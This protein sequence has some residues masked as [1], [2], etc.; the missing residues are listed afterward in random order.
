MIHVP[1][2]PDP[3]CAE[4]FDA[5]I[6][7]GA[8]SGAATAIQLLARNPGLRVG[9]IE[10]SAQFGR[11]VGESTVEVSSYFLGRVLGLTQHLNEKHLHKQGLRFF[12]SAG[13]EANLAECSELGPKYLPRLPGYQVDRAVLDEE[14]W[15]RA[16]AAGAV[17]FRPAQALGYERLASGGAVVRL[18]TEAGEQS[19]QA[20][21]L[22]DASGVRTLV[23][24]QEGWWES[25]DEHPTAS[26]WSRW[27]GVQDLDGAALRKA[28]P[29]WSA[30][31][32]GTRFTATNHLVGYGWWSW[33]IPL[34]DGDMSV[35]IVFDQRLV[36]LPEGPS[37]GAR[38]R[39]FLEQHPGAR[40]LLAHAEFTEGDVHL[41]RNLAY[42]TTRMAEDGVLLVGDA[43]G[44]MDPFYS[45]GLDWITYTSA[46]AAKVVVDE[47]A[48]VA[49]GA[50]LA[51]H[52]DVTFRQS[53]T[54][55]FEA[56]YR[57]K[58]FYLGDYELMSLA[59]RLDLGL[60]YLGVASQPYLR[61]PESLVRPSFGDR[62]STLPFYLIR[63]YHRRLV[64]IAQARRER[65]VWG[66]HN[67]GR[68]LPFNSYRFHPTLPIRVGWALLNWGWLEICEGWRSW[69]RKAAPVVKPTPAP[70]A[71]SS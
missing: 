5:L 1:P 48:G 17:P 28:H 14:V 18:R 22:I 45:P 42:R 70:C 33:W 66:R 64:R 60:Y 65:G 2:P 25:N 55:W 10:R 19:L 3:A 15:Q 71:P 4:P 47:R 36:E 26:L 38:L 8:L 21:W 68:F 12:F 31:C 67:R 63:G 44:F 16:I 53:Y 13:G 27:K 41:R 39:A 34:K 49:T 37:L 11:R 6:I 59:F 56:L 24:R 52:Y 46:A 54:R 61:G 7:G 20:R 29:E 40:E 30:R 43:A 69:G 58:Y 51:R 9:I 35:G 32:F 23:A 57:D 62:T 50:E